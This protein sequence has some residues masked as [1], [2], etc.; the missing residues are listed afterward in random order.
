M[1]THDFDTVCESD[2]N[3]EPAKNTGE[4]PLPQPPQDP[5]TLLTGRGHEDST[6]A[7]SGGDYDQKFVRTG[8]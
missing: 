3:V 8:D 6:A 2:G 7:C 1:W 4:F 5:I